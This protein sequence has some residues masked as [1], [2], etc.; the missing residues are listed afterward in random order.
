MPFRILHSRCLAFP[1]AVPPTG[2]YFYNWLAKVQNLESLSLTDNASS[3]PPLQDELTTSTTIGG[4]VVEVIDFKVTQSCNGLTISEEVGRIELPHAPR[5]TCNPK[6]RYFGE[7]GGHL[8]LIRVQILYANKFIVLELD[9]LMWSMKYLVHLAR[10]I[11]AFP[12]MAQQTPSGTQ[13]AYSI[14]SLMRGEMEEDSVLLLTIP[15][16][17][18]GHN[19]VLKTVK[20]IRELPGEVHDTLRFDHLSA[21][22][23]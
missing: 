13:Y 4:D 21:Y 3:L 17:V 18:V 9:T 8:H 5:G 1:N 6:M 10:L 11:S 14:L 19:L 7:S 23:L 20:A 2:I 12:E 22:L 16:K 15:G